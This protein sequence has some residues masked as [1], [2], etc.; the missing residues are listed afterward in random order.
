MK[1]VCAFSEQLKTVF[2]SLM[3]ANEIEAV[4]Q[5]TRGWHEVVQPLS[6]QSSN[7]RLQL[8]ILKVRQHFN[9]Q[10]IFKFGIK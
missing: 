9:F 4:Q 2:I 7:R 1:C 3:A 5:T 6:P 8:I 10:K